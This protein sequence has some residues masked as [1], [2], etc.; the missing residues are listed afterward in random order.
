MTLCL[1]DWLPGAHAAEPIAR[2]P[3]IVRSSAGVLLALF[4]ILS[5]DRQGAVTNS[6]WP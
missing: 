5:Y 3:L 6:S 4:L 2:R 1:R